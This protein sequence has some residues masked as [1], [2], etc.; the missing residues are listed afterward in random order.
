MSEKLEHASF[1]IL[2]A[3]VTVVFGFLL[4]P[5]WVSLLWASIIA[6]LFHPLQVRLGRMWGDGPT[7]LPW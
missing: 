4:M 7:S 6:V 2:L 1:L 5:F 3:L